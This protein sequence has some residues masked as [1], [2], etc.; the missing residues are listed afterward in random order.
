M[1]G[2]GKLLWPEFSLIRLVMESVVGVE[3]WRG[4]AVYSV[5]GAMDCRP[6][7][8]IESS[9]PPYLKLAHLAC[10]VEGYVRICSYHVAVDLELYLVWKVQ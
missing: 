6:R 2:L 10:E 3:D 9:I 1:E 5:A 8:D 7:E 4:F